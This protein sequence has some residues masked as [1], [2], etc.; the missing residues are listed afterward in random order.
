[1]KTST[2]FWRAILLWHGRYWALI[3]LY[4][5]EYCLFMVPALIAREILNT[6]S[7]NA[8]ARLSIAMLLVLLSVAE[9][10]KMA[11][12]FAILAVETTHNNLVY[13]VVRGNLF[14]R[15]LQ[16]P[17]A[18]AV[19]GPV[20]EG[21][22]V[23]RDDVESLG[24]FFS[25]SYNLI[26]YF[27]FALIALSVMLSINP[28]VTFVVF[29]PLAVITIIVNQGRRR[30][31]HYRADSRAST[32]RVSGALGE[33]FS[34]VE[35]IKVAGG[36][37]RVIDHLHALGVERQQK[38]LRE[39]LFTEMLNAISGNIGQLGT[40]LILLLVG[41]AL[42]AKAFKVGD[43]ALFVFYVG[44][45]ANFTNIVT[46]SVTI[47]RQ[48]GISKDRMVRLL[49]GAVPETL[50]ELPSFALTHDELPALHYAAKT[51]RDR[52]GFLAAYRLSYHYPDSTRGITN[53]SLLL[54]RGSFTVVTGQIGAGKT[55]LLHAVLGLLPLDNG[56]IYWNHKLVED[57]PSFFVPP[58]SSY[59][60]QVP[61]LFSETLR[62][63]LL[64]GFPED[65]IDL[66]AALHA[67]V[68]EDD[69]AGMEQG[70]DTVLGP[71]GVRLSGGQAQR[72]AAARMF[73]RD[74][75][76]LV[77]DDLSSALDVDT[78]WLLW[79]RLM[80]E[81]RTDQRA[82]TCLVVSHRRAVLQRAD[83]VIVLKDGHVEAEGTLKEL[84]TTSVEMRS[85]WDGQLGATTD[86]G[87]G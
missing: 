26:A 14:A 58:R 47:F 54:P 9:L 70:L 53:V 15:I 34:A 10:A 17:G 28:T 3:A 87:S 19:P 56:E 82:S 46:R 73:V 36:E 18:R 64:L 45:V 11:S 37:S 8:P 85:L 57:P 71:R 81:H 23:F 13:S 20:G 48:A 79:E 16:R 35:A 52:L 24:E 32:S 30:I 63:N 31:D 25:T 55:T 61:H 75:E 7:G 78:E 76:L 5:F 51:E 49:Q 83:H 43:F 59:T 69:L 66:N 6:L 67:A 22:N 60:P 80:K 50:V 65:C 84:L 39:R 38:A 62:D 21:V 27:G 72:T 40:G 1:M 41:Q 4:V 74:A 77:C 12:F 68:L 44:W 86:A 2:Y 33:M 29:L 42:E